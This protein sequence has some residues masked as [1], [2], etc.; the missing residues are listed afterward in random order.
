MS[1]AL[2]V[3]PVLL[4]VASWFGLKYLTRNVESL[5]GVRSSM[6][7][8]VVVMFVLVQFW[9]LVVSKIIPQ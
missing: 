1:I 5:E 7:T 4:A 8:M 6:L 9:N 3:V 2:F